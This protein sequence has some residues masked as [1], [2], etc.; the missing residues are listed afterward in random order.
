MRITRPG[1]ISK[2]DPIVKAECNRCGCE[3]EAKQSELQWEY[4]QRDGIGLSRQFCMTCGG[5]VFFYRDK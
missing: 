2:I 5:N 1:D 3:M 4:D